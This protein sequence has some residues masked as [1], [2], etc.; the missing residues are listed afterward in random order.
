M[1]LPGL[2]E[3]GPSSFIFALASLH[4]KINDDDPY[5]VC[6][7]VDV[8]IGAYL[9]WLSRRIPNANLRRA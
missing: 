6:F 7:S 1:A 9:L 3:K 8:V 2:R 4:G 5:S